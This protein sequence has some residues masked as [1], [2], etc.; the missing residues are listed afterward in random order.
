MGKRECKDYSTRKTY[1]KPSTQKTSKQQ[2]QANNTKKTSVVSLGPI[3]WDTINLPK[4]EK[5][6]YEEPRSIKNLTVA[7]INKWRTDNNITTF[8]KNPP[9]PILSFSETPFADQ[10]TSILNSS[11]SG[12]TPIQSQSWPIALS[13]RDMVGIASTGSGKTLAFILPALIHIVAQ[14]KIQRGEGPIG[15]VLAPTRELA[16]QIS[17]VDLPLLP[18]I[19]LLL[20]S[21]TFYWIRRP[22]NLL[23][24]TMSAQHVFM[25]V[26][27]IVVFNFNS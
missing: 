16:S 13:G 6:F 27:V 3:D 19:H 7:Q 14:P 23:K 10:V 12:P 15:L 26:K 2:N 1:K 21:L 22:L 18:T 5:N 17:E 11:F 8:G 9:K 20:L 25:E 24:D 4:F